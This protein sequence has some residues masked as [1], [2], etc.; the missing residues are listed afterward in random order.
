MISCGVALF[1]EM[2]SSSF[3]C[4]EI[5]IDFSARENT[6]PPLEISLVS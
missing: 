4:G 1:L 5:G 2:P 3:I 6:P